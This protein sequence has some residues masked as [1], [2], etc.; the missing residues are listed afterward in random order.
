MDYVSWIDL[1]DFQMNFRATH[2]ISISNFLRR[3]C[4]MSAEVLYHKQTISVSGRNMNPSSCDDSI[5]KRVRLALQSFKNKYSS[6]SDK[7]KANFRA[8]SDV[9]SSNL[10]VDLQD[11]CLDHAEV[12][13]DLGIS[14]CWLRSDDVLAIHCYH[15]NNVLEIKQ[16]LM[17]AISETDFLLGSRLKNVIK[18]KAQ[19]SIHLELCGVFEPTHSSEVIDAALVA[20]AS[21]GSKSL[22]DLLPMKQH[23]VTI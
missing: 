2:H 7:E 12:L 15:L 18:S 1:H 19:L 6:M 8:E 9:S 14:K 23:M 21:A 11:W 10:I 20:M 5:G 22:C 4:N 3:Y 16:T 17:D 13:M